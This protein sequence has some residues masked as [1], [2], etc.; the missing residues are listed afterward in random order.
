M[1]S[2]YR[3]KVFLTGLVG[4]VAVALVVSCNMTI[5]RQ[6]WHKK[7]GP[8]VPHRTFPGDCGICHLTDGWDTLREDFS[9]DHEKETGR[10][11]EGAHD[12]A[13]CLRCHNDRGPV[14]DYLVRGCGGCHPDPHASAL[15]L[16]CQSCHGQIDWRPTGLIAEHATTRFHLVAAHAVV[17]CESCH[18]Q[19]AIGQFRGTPTQ[20]EFCHQRSLASASTPDHAANGWT[21]NCE[22]CHTAAGWTGG[23]FEHHFFPLTGA[24]AGLLCTSCHTGGDFQPIPSDCYS[25]HSDDFPRGPDHVAMDFPHNCEQCHNTTAWTPASFQHSFLLEG[26]HNV[27]C[28]L[29]HTTGTTSTFDCLDCH[30]QG[31]TD[32]IHD[33]VSGYSYNSSAC[34]QCHPDGR[35]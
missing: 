26:D 16:D 6:R 1:G 21:T 27:A 19:A 9:F 14:T 33:E 12:G 11:L 28:T 22:R 25:C 24:H 31:D 20:C 15:G 29:C 7:W 4:A 2:A 17:P 32:N 3:Q 23:N 35:E 18:L 34:Y 30:D 10:S 13:A 5:P 8:L